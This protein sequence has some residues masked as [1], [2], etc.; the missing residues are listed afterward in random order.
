MK[1][2][3]LTGAF[4][5]SLASALLPVTAA[6]TELNAIETVD[7]AK[8]G[9]DIVVRLSMKQPLTQVPASFSV[10]SP[11]RIAFD[12]PNTRSTLQN[13]NQEIGEGDLRSYTIVQVGDR[14]RMVLNLNKAMIQHAQIDGKTLDIRLT[15]CAT[16][17]A[18]STATRFAESTTSARHAVKNVDFRRGTAGRGRVGVDLLE[19]DTGIDIRTQGN[20]VVVDFLKTTLPE[21]LRKRF[22]VTD[23]GTPVST[24]KVFEQGDNARLV[25]TPTGLWEHNAYQTDNQFVVEVKPVQYDPNKLVQGTRGGY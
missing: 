6:A 9:G 2:I 11:P 8:H 4:L 3:T 23:F 1:A 17:S 15:P 10:M 13:N 7:V 5:L 14:A 20:T 22:D 19:A 21:Q 24:V 16:A 12:F 25:I 18:K